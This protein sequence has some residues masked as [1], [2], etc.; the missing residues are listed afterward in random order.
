MESISFLTRRLSKRGH[1]SADSADGFT[2]V[3]MLVVLAI[4]GI[5]LV[6]VVTGQSTFSRTLLLTDTAYT[7]AL[8]I[9]EAQTYGLSSHLFSGDQNAAYG[10]HFTPNS[11]NYTEF[12]DIYPAAPGTNSTYCPGHTDTD[13]TK[14]DARPGNCLY[15]SAQGEL[16]QLYT[17]GQGYTI[18][19]IKGI[20]SAGGAVSPS[21]VDITF[22]RPNILTV[23][24]ANVSGVYEALSQVEISVK[25]PQN[26]SKCLVVN[27]LGEISVQQSCP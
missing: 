19:S 1:Y 25:S 24:V 8:S 21:S 4:I 14:P 6:V 23:I 20:L 5:I 2:L 26:N 7:V 3:E 15:D 27:N 13:P 18:G 10:V 9:R 12:G 11:T 17:F 16:I 22:Q